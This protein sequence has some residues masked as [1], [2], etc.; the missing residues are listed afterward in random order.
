VDEDIEFE[1]MI[2]HA[3]GALT[4]F[5][6]E[7][8]QT[9]A[10]HFWNLLRGSAVIRRRKT[11]LVHI[12]DG[13]YG[14]LASKTLGIPTVVTVHDL[15]PLLRQEGEFGPARSNRI[16]R[17]LLGRVVAGLQRS[18]R[19]IAVSS[20]TEKDLRQHAHID[21]GRISVAPLALSSKFRFEG[22]Q[23]DLKEGRYPDTPYLLHVGNNGYYKN[24][25]GV[26]RIFSQLPEAQR[27][28]LVMAGPA[29]TSQLTSLIEKLGLQA[30]VEFVID[31][32]DDELVGLYRRAS[33]F[34]FPS[35][36]EGFG[37]PPL[38][39]M[40]CGCPVVCSTEGSLPGVVGDAALT[41]QAQNEEALTAHCVKVLT[42]VG[43][44]QSLAERGRERVKQFTIERM[45]EDLL[46][47]YGRALAVQSLRPA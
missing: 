9:W 31:S 17:W 19:L 11:D 36:Y 43:L 15:I 29:P 33:L 3:T 7:R 32:D 16:S 6:G 22:S 10:R 45:R 1:R 12:L 46:A 20:N 28:R 44:A 14:Y 18:E 23:G 4:G 25:E 5:L 13:S 47:A 8:V 27:A 40:A 35:L 39:A 24:R 42:D 2:L 21:Q 26:V 38:E 41:A 34:L 30:R 37:W